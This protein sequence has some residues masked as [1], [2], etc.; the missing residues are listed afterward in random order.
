[1]NPYL[2]N[3]LFCFLPKTAHIH[4]GIKTT[5][6]ITNFDGRTIALLISKDSPSEQSGESVT[7]KYSAD[8]LKD[9]GV[10]LAERDDGTPQR[11]RAGDRVTIPLFSEDD[12]SFSWETYVERLQKLHTLLDVKS[13][14][15]VYEFLESLVGYNFC[16]LP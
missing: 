15:T 2:S 9:L 8:A 11:L 12:A 16:R 7:F 14:N 13:G 5:I 4:L 6:R 10:E 1:M 3:P